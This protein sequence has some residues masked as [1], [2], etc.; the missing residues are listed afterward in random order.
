MKINVSV[1]YQPHGELALFYV[2]T[3]GRTQWLECFD[4]K[5]GHSEVSKSYYLKCTPAA[6]NDSVRRLVEF[7]DSIGLDRHTVRIVSRLSTGGIK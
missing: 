7:W 1:R 5:E 2:N 6:Q 3:N 4:A